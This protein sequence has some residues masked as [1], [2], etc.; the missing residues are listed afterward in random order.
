M[1]YWMY[2]GNSQVCEWIPD[3]KMMNESIGDYNENAV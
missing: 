3:K 1:V 2:S